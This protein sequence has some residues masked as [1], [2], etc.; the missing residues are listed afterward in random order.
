MAAPTFPK[1]TDTGS[2]LA[3]LGPFY[4]DHGR[5]LLITIWSFCVPC[6]LSLLS[7]LISALTGVT[8]LVAASQGSIGVLFYYVSALLWWYM[9]PFA[10][11]GSVGALALA[12]LSKPSSITKWNGL[13][14]VGAAW[15]AIAL[16][17]LI[18]SKL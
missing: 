3:T 8:P 2:A 10:V 14:V 18:F 13:A 7:V 11:L 6:F 4:K 5:W 16:A 1:T 12:L 9:F 15:I 17:H